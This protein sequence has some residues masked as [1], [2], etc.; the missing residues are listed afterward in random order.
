METGIHPG[1][2]YLQEH[3]LRQLFFLGLFFEDMLPTPPSGFC[4]SE[5]E[6]IQRN[7]WRNLN[8]KKTTTYPPGVN[9]Q[10]SDAITAPLC[11]VKC[12]G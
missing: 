4:R 12:N 7:K 1:H 6:A 8:D 3:K 5:E 10:R 9:L 11:F 2:I